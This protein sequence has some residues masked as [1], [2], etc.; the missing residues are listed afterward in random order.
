MSRSIL[1]ILSTFGLLTGC[2]NEDKFSEDYSTTACEHLEGC[3]TDIV[4]AYVALG[5]DEATAQVT[6]DTIHTATCDTEAEEGEEG[7]DECDFNSDEAQTCVDE[8]A[9]M[10]C[11]YY[12]TGAG[13]PESCG[14][15]CGG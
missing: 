3:E 6:Y 2:Y 1:L 8:Y 13:F 9:A 12:S 7:E 5:S 14:A 11:D 15:V 10:S 4:A